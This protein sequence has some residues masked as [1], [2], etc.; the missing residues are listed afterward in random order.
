[1]AQAN[2]HCTIDWNSTTTGTCPSCWTWP[3]QCGTTT[4]SGTITAWPS[5]Q[6]S[7]YADGTT[8]DPL[9]I[10]KIKLKCS[11]CKKRMGTITATQQPEDAVCETCRQIDKLKE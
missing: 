8:W 5:P 6:T 9:P 11:E 4:G 2:S 3:C 1:M 7:D 10:I